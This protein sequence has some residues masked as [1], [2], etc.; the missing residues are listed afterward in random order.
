MIAEIKESGTLKSKKKLIDQ[1]DHTC[2]SIWFWEI[3]ICAQLIDF[4]RVIVN[5]LY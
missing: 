1:L 4:V 3:V 2:W 5:K